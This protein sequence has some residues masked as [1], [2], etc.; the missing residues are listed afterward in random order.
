MAHI[1]K[2]YGR[3][4]FGAILVI[5]GLLMIGDKS[6]IIDFSWPLILIVAG[7]VI[8]GQAV[9]RRKSGQVF[10]GTFLL[11]IGMV[12]LAREYHLLP[13]HLAYGWSYFLFSVGGAL[14]IRYLVVPKE[15]GKLW[16]S[17]V[18]VVVGAV[19]MLA[20]TRWLHWH[21]YDNLLEWWPA[22]LI[23]VGLYLVTRRR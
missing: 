18:L 1:S 20:D 16:V 7:A 2:S 23:V 14:F 15:G 19:F 6:R 8:L 12:F 11:L 3:Y 9:P 13:H 21:R 10:F 4:T 22:V 17:L 5:L